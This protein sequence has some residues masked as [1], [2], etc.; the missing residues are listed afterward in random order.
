MNGSPENRKSVDDPAPLFTGHWVHPGPELL[1]DPVE[2][3]AHVPRCEAK[4]DEVRLADR[5]P[6]S[7][8]ET[9]VWDSD[10]GIDEKVMPPVALYVPN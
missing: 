3:D 2:P 7:D 5:V 9:P 10:G 6:H 1:T 4:H 8:R